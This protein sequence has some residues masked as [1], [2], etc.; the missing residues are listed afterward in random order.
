MKST[1]NRKQRPY[2]EPFENCSP[3]EQLWRSRRIGNSANAVDGGV[4]V[5]HLAGRGSKVAPVLFVSPCVLTE[6]LTENNIS[7]AMMLKGPQGAMPEPS[8]GIRRH[9]FPMFPTGA[10]RESFV[11]SKRAEGIQAIEQAIR[12][13]SNGF[14]LSARLS[15]RDTSRPN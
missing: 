14:Q 12:C 11:V 4:G 10:L 13:T 7:G 2:S 1:S 5:L 6:E 15:L 8:L 9:S 3:P